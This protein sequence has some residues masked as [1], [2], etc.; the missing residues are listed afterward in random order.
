MGQ[1][2]R[3]IDP[4]EVS[5]VRSGA[6]RKVW[7][8]FKSDDGEVELTKSLVDA[9]GEPFED[10]GALVDALR[11]SSLDDD[12]QEAVIASLRL[13][14]GFEGDLPEALAE[15]VTEILKQATAD[16]DDP[17]DIAKSADIA[18]R[19]FSADQ[20]RA[21]AG[22]GEALSDGS[23]PIA[24]TGDLRNAVRAVGRASDESKARAH[25]VSRA[26]SLGALDAL[27]DTWVQKSADD[28]GSDTEKETTMGDGPS[29]P[30]RKDDGT[31]DL[32]GVDEAQRPFY[33]TVLKGMEDAKAESEQLRQDVTK[34]G[35][36]ITELEGKLL[37]KDIVLKADDFKHVAE[38]D[39]LVVV[40]KAAKESMS[41][42]Q[43]TL[44][45]DVLTKANAKIETGALF[46]ELGRSADPVIKE[47]IRKGATV[48]TG[49][50]AWE[51]IE[52][53][54]EALIEKSDEELSRHAAID[55][56][57]KT[58]EGRALYSEYVAEKGR[59]A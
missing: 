1:E 24:N 3:H 59:V 16:D 38:R 49:G 25:I 9:L 18:K 33:S 7:N 31:W 55:R 17:E 42:E 5:P 51:K 46:A 29:V 27:P 13:L 50:D 34:A 52:K 37:E 44:L 2:L 58:D 54:A 23:F 15:K 22:N 20:R 57:L 21:M 41:D 35:E 26:R 10:E 12:A 43:Y 4:D 6:I 47:A 19:G 28:L 14:K 39:D 45:E 36:T 56:F 30:V 32:S 11:K 8:I 40:L 53:G 48:D